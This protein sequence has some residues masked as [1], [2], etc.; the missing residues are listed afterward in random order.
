[1]REFVDTYLN[2]NL[3][4]YRNIAIDLEI[5]KL[6]GLLFIGIMVAAVLMNLFK[7]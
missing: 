3:K 1:M 6:L 4:D 2:L 5:T 7:Q